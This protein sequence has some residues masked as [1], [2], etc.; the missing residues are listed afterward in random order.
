MNEV[1]LEIMKASA[2]EF[3][4]D[5]TWILQII[6]EFG[7]DV[8]AIVVEAMRQGLSKDL[9][10][11]II[12]KLGPMIL[13]IMIAVMNS[14]KMSF[15]PGD[16]QQANILAILIQQFLPTIVEVYLPELWQRNKEHII[17]MLVDAITASPNPVPQTT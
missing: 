12:T 9:V 16:P 4:F 3:G 5:P 1:Q 8:V 14:K 15:T 17:Q 7:P 10:V 13:Q 11:E 2:T 6:G